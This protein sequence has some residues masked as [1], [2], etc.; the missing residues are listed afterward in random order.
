MKNLLPLAAALALAACAT[1]STT[2]HTA[3][4]SAL[5]KEDR[6]GSRIPVRDS[7]GTAASPA[8]TL[9]PSALGPGAPV[10]TN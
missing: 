2:T 4:S 8:K 9:D 1:T 10:R 3:Q 7:S 5:D 6:T